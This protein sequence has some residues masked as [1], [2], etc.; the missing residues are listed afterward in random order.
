MK[1]SLYRET[2][3]LTWHSCLYRR[4]TRS[5]RCMDSESSSSSYEATPSLGSWHRNDT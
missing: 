4:C 1:K 5:R 3:V 2:R